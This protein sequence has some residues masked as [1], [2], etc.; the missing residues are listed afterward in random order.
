[1]FPFVPTLRACDPPNKA[2]RRSLLLGGRQGF[3]PFGCTTASK[4]SIT[5]ESAVKLTIKSKQG[6]QTYSTSSF[7]PWSANMP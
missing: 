1:M 7:L 5:V 2:R 4:G 3:L 6:Q